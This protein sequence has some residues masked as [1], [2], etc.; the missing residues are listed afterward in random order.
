MVRMNIPFLSLPER[1][2]GRLQSKHFSDHSH[3]VLKTIEEI[4][5]PLEL[6]SDCFVV[7][8]EYIIELLMDLLETACM[9]A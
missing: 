5:I 2:R 6:I 4:R 9:L 7:G 3:G 1:A 8:T